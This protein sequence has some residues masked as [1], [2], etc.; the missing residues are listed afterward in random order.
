[1][2]DMNICNKQ[3][4]KKPAHAAGAVIFALVM[5]FNPNIN[6]IDIFP[7]FI[8]YFILARL[9][10]KA[11]DCAPYFEEA[12][13]SFL[14]LAYLTL[15]K[16]P[17]LVIITV[18]RSN[19]TLD[20]DIVTLFTL[21]FAVSELILLIPAIKNTF[22]ALTYLGER[23]G[24]ESLIKSDTLHS[25]ESLR[26][27]STFFVIFKS[28][29]CLLPE[30][31]N[32]T[33][34]VELSSGMYMATGSKYYPFALLTAL[35]LGLII[36]IVWLTRTVKYVKCIRNEGKFYDSLYAM[37]NESSLAEY[38]KRRKKRSIAS[39]FLLFII[40]SVL[41]IDLSFDNL[42]EVNLLPNVLFV[43]F[44]T[45]ALFKL[46]R[47]T[48]IAKSRIYAILALCAAYGII[49]V[50]NSVF[51]FGFLTEHGYEALYESANATAAAEYRRIQILSVIETLMHVA[52]FV[53][54]TLVMRKYS[55]ENIGISPLSESYRPSDRQYHKEINA[56]TYA[57]SAIAIISGMANLIKVISSGSVQ[58]I[59]TDPNDVTQPTIYASAIPWISTAVTVVNIIFILYS[60]YYFNYIKSEAFDCDTV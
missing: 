14:K 32:L 59:F 11:A 41:T 10:D 58:L 56:R 18:V 31:L 28:V 35:T 1:M 33:R 16:I 50:I 34:S 40:A 60:V 49:S 38:E 26:S 23:T 25:T 52:A 43:I 27:F 55:L 19:N 36:G 57:Y 44:F 24:A 15:A 9:F 6:I 42:Y 30:L 47:H 4:Y 13:S 51:S 29:F 39:T 8:A 53:I 37:A 48:G 21:I 20:N 46:C 22:S 17:A 2:Q 12:R 45:V 3:A 54:F 5:L 7:D